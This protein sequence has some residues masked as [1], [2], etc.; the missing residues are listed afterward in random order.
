MPRDIFSDDPRDSAERNSSPLISRTA[1]RLRANSPH[2]E[3]PQPND[4]RARAEERSFPHPRKAEPQDSPR[5]YYLGDRAYLLRESELLTLVEIGTF[6]AI[7]AADLGRFACG[8]D[9]QR[10]E[11]DVRHLKEQSLISEK[12]LRAGRK[13]TIRLFALTRKGARLAKRSATVPE[14]QALFHGFVK[15]REAKHDADLYRLYHAEAER[16]EQAGG[17]V[18]RVVLDYE[19]K[20][21]L[22]RELATLPPEERSSPEARERLAQ[23]H[24]LAVVDGKIPIPDIRIEYDTAEMERGHLDLELATRNYRPRALVQKAKAGF[25]FYALR[26]DASRLRRVLDEREIT[27]EILSL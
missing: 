19:L 7:A 27:A 5:A 23:H 21:N 18:T 13:H 10:M 17:R 22:N 26:E 11:R 2:P 24:G 15:P 25:S 6:R 16:I 14:D 9:T 4:G 20:R 3:V 8:G 1:P 12:V